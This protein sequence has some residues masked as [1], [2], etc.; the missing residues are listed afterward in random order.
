M[1]APLNTKQTLFK[2]DV[3]AIV[4]RVGNDASQWKKILKHDFYAQQLDAYTDAQAETILYYVL[5]KKHF[6]IRK[7]TS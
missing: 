6:T 7:R 5:A 4:T 3:D 1:S 2:T